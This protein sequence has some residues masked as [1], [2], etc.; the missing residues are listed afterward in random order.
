MKSLFYLRCAFSAGILVLLA[1]CAG[2]HSVTGLTPLAQPG[3]IASKQ[4]FVYTG[5]EQKFKVPAGVTQIVVTVDGASGA[6]GYDDG[7][8]SYAS[9]GG[10]GSRVRATIPVTPRETLAIFVGGNGSQGGF[11]GGGSGNGY[12]GSGGGASDVRQGGDKVKDRVIVAAGGG[13][14]GEAGA[15]VT[16]TCG[17][18]TGGAGGVGGKMRGGLGG[19]ASGTLGGSGGGGGRQSA[20]GHGGA[21]GAG[22]CSGSDGEQGAG[23]A[24]GGDLSHCGNLGGGGGGGYYGGGGG[25]GGGVYGSSPS[26]FAAA[27][28]GGGGGSSFA[29]KS[30]G[31]VYMHAGKRSG[32]GVIVISW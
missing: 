13:G 1:G 18:T 3:G 5:N 31:N 28:G 12:G 19:N 24:G 20:G 8:G 7:Y 26:E 10:L 6:P 25:G 17:Y 21:G 11:N 27:G 16:T 2:A 15:C 32:N 29:E 9:P 22:S 4:T 23:G 14:G 30:A